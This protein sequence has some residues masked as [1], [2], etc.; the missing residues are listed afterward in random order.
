MFGTEKQAYIKQ[1]CS[2]IIVCV[3]N[4]TSGFYLSGDIQQTNNTYLLYIPVCKIW[5]R[6][7]GRKYHMLWCDVRTISLIIMRSFSGTKWQAEVQS[8]QK[9][10]VKF[11]P[12]GRDKAELVLG[13]ITSLLSTGSTW[14]LPE[15]K[16]VGH[17]GGRLHWGATSRQIVDSLAVIFVAQFDLCSCPQPSP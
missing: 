12:V 8:Q 4:E 15:L 13:Q 2:F 9:L 7:V 17:K 16:R 10:A 1:K 3:S 6:S 5:N 14:L 11:V